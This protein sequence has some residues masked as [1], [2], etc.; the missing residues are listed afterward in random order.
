MWVLIRVHFKSLFAGISDLSAIW[1]LITSGIT[2]I[3]SI[4]GFVAFISNLT[5]FNQA[6][7]CL[8]E[9][10]YLLVVVGSIASLIHKHEKTSCKRKLNNADLQVEV[11]VSDLFSEEASS[12]VIPTN[13]FF[14]TVMEG[15]YISPQSVQGAFQLK[16]FK[17]NSKVLDTLIAESLKQQGLVGIDDSDIHGAV[18][19]FP[20]G[21]VAKIDYN[22]KHYYFVAVNDVNKNGR[23][24]NQG[25]NNVKEAIDGLITTINKIGHCD[26]LAMPLIGT[27]RAAILE[28]TIEKVIVETIDKFLG[29]HDKIVNK[30]TIC[31]RPKAYLEDKVDLKRIKTYI[32][33]KCEFG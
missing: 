25:Y 31:I 33:Y 15:E 26:H 1:D 30:L 13:T 28:A 32:D 22:G 10:W 21:T 20:V 8:K 9:Y 2:Y 6:E 17:N 11:K 7:I 14:R 23:P 4:Y 18:R 5:G 3:M 16:Y 12:Y 24:V 19:R 29:S 27:G